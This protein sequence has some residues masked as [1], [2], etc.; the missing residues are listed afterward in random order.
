M[1][2]PLFFILQ[3]NKRRQDWCD[4]S[5][6]HAIAAQ[7]RDFAVTSDSEEVIVNGTTVT[8]KL[9]LGWRSQSFTN[10]VNKI[11]REINIAARIGKGK[12]RV[13]NVIPR[14]EAVNE[15]EDPRIPEKLSRQAYNPT[16]LAPLG[17]AV[18]EALNI[19]DFDVIKPD[20]S[21]IGG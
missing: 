3:I 7:F 6:Y 14:L 1:T 15:E 17:E 19:R 2:H 4:A 12:R 21:L 18:K 9:R 10:L 11:D 8:R 13:T 5:G 16:W 20:G